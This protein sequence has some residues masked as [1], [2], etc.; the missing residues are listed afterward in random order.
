MQPSA[1]STFMSYALCRPIGSLLLVTCDLT[2]ECYTATHTGYLFMIILPVLFLWSGIVP[3][4]LFVKLFRNRAKLGSSFIINLRYGYLFFEYRRLAYF[5]EFCKII[6]K[7]F[8]VL[9]L[10]LFDQYV[11]TKSVIVC[12]IMLTYLV[13]MIRWSPYASRQLNNIE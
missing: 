8:I 13:S 6:E 12:L 4:M 5:W 1:V 3:A 7:T 10:N 11:K 9:A 2:Y